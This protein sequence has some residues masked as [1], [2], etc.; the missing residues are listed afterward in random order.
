MIL[1][2]TTQLTKTKETIVTNCIMSNNYLSKSNTLF[3]MVD[4]DRFMYNATRLDWRLTEFLAFAGG[5]EG[6][7]E[8]ELRDNGIHVDPDD[9]E[10]VPLHR[11][12]FSKYITQWKEAW[13]RKNP[14]YQPL[15]TEADAN[16][17]AM[18]SWDPSRQMIRQLGPPKQLIEPQLFL[19]TQVAGFSAFQ[20]MG[21]F[22]AGFTASESFRK[23]QGQYMESR[24]K[25]DEARAESRRKEDEARRKEDEARAE[26]EKEYME[27]RRKEEKDYWEQRRKED[28]AKAERQ[29]QE[30]R[31]DKN[32]I[33][34]QL[35]STITNTGNKIIAKCATPGRK[36]KGDSPDSSMSPSSHGSDDDDASSG[37]NDD[38]VSANKKPTGRRAESSLGGSDS[39]LKLLRKRTTSTG[40]PVSPIRDQSNDHPVYFFQ[41]VKYF[42]SC[43]NSSRLQSSSLKVLSE[44]CNSEDTD[45]L[46]HLPSA[47]LL[48]HRDIKNELRAWITEIQNQKGNL[49]EG[50]L[51]LRAQCVLV[52][53]NAIYQ[54][55]DE[56]DPEYDTDNY[57]FVEEIDEIPCE[58]N[59]KISMDKFC[60]V[61]CPAMGRFVNLSIILVFKF[62]NLDED[63]DGET[64]LQLQV[65]SKD[66]ASSQPTMTE[67][68]KLVPELM[69]YGLIS[70]RFVSNK[71][72]PQFYPD[73]PIQERA[74]PLLVKTN[75]LHII[76]ENFQL[77]EKP[78][79][80]LNRSVARITFADCKFNGGGST[81][82]SKSDIPLKVEFKG[83]H[84]E[85]FPKLTYLA[86]AME[87]GFL[88][89]LSMEML[90]EP[91]KLRGP[92]DRYN[93]ERFCVGAVRMGHRVCW[94][95][96]KR[97]RFGCF[98]DM[99]TVTMGQFDWNN[100]GSK[101]T[102]DVVSEIFAKLAG[103]SNAKLTAASKDSNLSID[104]SANAKA[105]EESPNTVLHSNL[106]SE[107]N[108]E[109]S[110]NKVLHSN[111]NSKAKEESA[112]EVSNLDDNGGKEEG[113]K[114]CS[115]RTIVSFDSPASPVAKPAIRKSRRCRTA[116][117]SRDYNDL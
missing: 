8:A 40:A 39:K 91:Y 83:K 52:H 48:T 95:D 116:A 79:E 76:F 72:D 37:S 7:I 110:A 60:D 18:A 80:H 32:F 114:L 94:G 36:K 12:N 56:Y 3:L 104:S 73:L 66:F 53:T 54:S 45:G 29:R 107:A 82:L 49:D 24:R 31:Q 97:T 33:V 63:A 70:C 109:E 11:T 75:D 61:M 16:N 43:Q 78:Q 20:Q 25:E 30:E 21:A 85:C 58:V 64:I 5:G 13:K 4:D 115:R 68:A 87:H 14:N 55:D 74:I 57:I 34:T 101:G 22:T 92:E 42:L 108:E 67:V 84:D 93:L 111:S 9:H 89:H 112:N 10:F 27:S 44:I 26:K 51:P 15:A 6:V 103:P 1:N 28:E 117:K 98:T 47:K 59:R 2:I 86:S 99:P 38:D 65:A 96:N 81:L 17:G 90:M 105:K 100:L 46:N 69:D 106:N 88:E 35:T 102:R 41:R 62:G 113:T 77:N 71:S 50:E 23:E 19:P